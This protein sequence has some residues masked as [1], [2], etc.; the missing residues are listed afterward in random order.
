M[1]YT[2]KTEIFPLA[3]LLACVALS[4]F[5]YAN[6][7]EIVVTH[8]NFR[9]EADGFSP[10]SFAS[11]FFPGLL[12]GM[13]LLFLILP[14][15]DPKKERYQDFAKTYNIFRHLIV[16]VLAI[17]Y[18]ATGVYNIGYHI[19]IG[20]IVAW[21]I[22]LMMIILGNYMGKI[23]NNWFMGIRTPWTLSS[24]NVW[25]KTHRLG[26]RLFIIFGLIMMVVPFLSETIGMIL[27]FGWAV[28]L[29]LGTFVYSYWLYHQETK[30]K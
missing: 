7:P 16:G 27:F 28:V 23:K 15:F 10:R 14:N 11:F 24:E 8:W 29:L 25:N 12:V 26:G 1:K 5:F 21:T 20:V 6:S 17:V 3:V 2:F 18:V 4:F 30:K 9:G 22:G 19:N 13:Y